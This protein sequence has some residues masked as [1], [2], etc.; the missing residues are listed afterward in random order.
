MILLSV[1]S[2]AWSSPLCVCQ[3]VSRP[4]MP[5]LPAPID[6]SAWRAMKQPDHL[7]RA[8]L[9]FMFPKCLALFT[10]LPSSVCLESLINPVRLCS[11]KESLFYQL[12]NPPFYILHIWVCMWKS[13]FLPMFALPPWLRNS[14]VSS[15]SHSFFYQWIPVVQRQSFPLIR[16]CVSLT[17]LIGANFHYA[18]EGRA[19]RASHTGQEWV[20]AAVVYHSVWHPCSSP[21][22]PPSPTHTS[23]QSVTFLSTED[24]CMMRSHAGPWGQCLLCMSGFIL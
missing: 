3:L 7:T 4:G 11:E 2:S 17:I 8:L 15:S 5:S 19:S 24:T 18:D 16:P 22:M 13:R 20:H 23:S 12:L 6:S 21:H 14:S 9:L 1:P 10:K